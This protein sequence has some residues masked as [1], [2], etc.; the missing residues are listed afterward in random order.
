[1]LNST[2]FVSF[3]WQQGAETLDRWEVAALD[4]LL[5]SGDLLGLRDVLLPDRA[6]A[7]EDRATRMHRAGQVLRPG[8][9]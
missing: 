8:D 4:R 1:M 6:D 2:E 7:L 5:A 9:F 3:R